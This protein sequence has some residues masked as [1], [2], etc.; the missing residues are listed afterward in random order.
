MD[1]INAPTF[2]GAVDGM[3]RTWGIQQHTFGMLLNEPQAGS[4]NIAFGNVVLKAPA[5]AQVRSIILE[6]CLIDFLIHHET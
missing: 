4:Y 3:I 2:V 1:K 5:Q 6:N